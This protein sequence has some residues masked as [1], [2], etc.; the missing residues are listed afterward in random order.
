MDPTTMHEVWL[1]LATNSPFLAFVI[2]NWY[3][4]SR[5]NEAYRQ[6]MKADREQY[7]KKRE[8]A[9][10]DIRIRYSKVIEELKAE[11]GQGIEQRL[12]TLEK[13]IK[14]IFAVV[15]SLKKSVEEIQLKDKI[16]DLNH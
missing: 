4:Q 8:E 10:E 3:Q 14:K 5:Q 16:R 15:D 9:I 11:R 12:L 7:E 6:E 1:N 2:Y 13:S